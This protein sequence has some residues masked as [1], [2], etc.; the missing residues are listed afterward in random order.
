MGRLYSV[1]KRNAREEYGSLSTMAIHL[2]P[3]FVGPCEQ[4]STSTS[5]TTITITIRE[6]STTGM[7][8]FHSSVAPRRRGRPTGEAP[9]Q[10]ASGKSLNRNRNRTRA[11]A[12]LFNGVTNEHVE[13]PASRP[14]K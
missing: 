8:V 13:D 7:V 10:T 3:R 14:D 1:V 11:R 12:R 6:A 9:L 2:T 5:T 4:T